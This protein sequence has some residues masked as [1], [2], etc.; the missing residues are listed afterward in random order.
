ML[1]KY[2]SLGVL[3]IQNCSQMLLMR[4]SLTRGGQDGTYLASTA[5]AITEVIKLIMSA[6]FVFYECGYN[7]DATMRTLHD[8]IWA[9]PFDTL[10]VGVP[11]RSPLIC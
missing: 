1:A 7:L 8:Q 9:A 6:M 4:Y 2:V 5:V 11:V 10:K 3:V